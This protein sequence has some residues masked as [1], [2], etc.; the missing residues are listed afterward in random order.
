L[1]RVKGSD[2]LAIGSLLPT[3]IIQT[4]TLALE[5]QV[6]EC[7]VFFPVFTRRPFDRGRTSR[8]R[9]SWR[10]TAAVDIFVPKLKGSKV[11]VRAEVGPRT[12]A[13]RDAATAHSWR[14]TVAVGIFVPKLKGSKVEV[15]HTIGNCN[16]VS[17]SPQNLLI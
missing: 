14:I 10:I 3:G 12:G 5:E 2:S 16:V 4:V 6:V 17:R 9:T 8:G 7:T 13:T 15:R 1:A 11:E